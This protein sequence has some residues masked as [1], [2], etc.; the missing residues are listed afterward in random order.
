MTNE[1]LKIQALLERVSQEAIRSANENADLRVALTNALNR[2]AELEKYVARPK[3]TF[4]TEAVE[5]D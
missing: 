4:A 3:E 2:V 5:S 1:E